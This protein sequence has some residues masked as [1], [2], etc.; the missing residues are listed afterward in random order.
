MALAEIVNTPPRYARFECPD[1]DAMSYVHRVE[2]PSLHSG[3]VVNGAGT[4][5]SRAPADGRA[6]L[7]VTGRYRC[8]QSR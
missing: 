1:G 7:F 2:H 5:R 4:G 3:F 8:A 6:A